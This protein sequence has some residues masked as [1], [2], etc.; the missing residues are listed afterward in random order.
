MG[1]WHQQVANFHPGTS[2]L[3][4]LAH[5][6]NML[7]SFVSQVPTDP[8][9]TEPVYLKVANFHPGTSQWSISS[10]NKARSLAEANK[11]ALIR[12]KVKPA[13]ATIGE[14]LAT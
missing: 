14:G 12:G 7:F 4:V 2:H 6:I 3:T 9:I 13:A 8:P 1:T 11:A 10:G 5:V